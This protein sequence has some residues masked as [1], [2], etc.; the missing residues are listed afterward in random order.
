MIKASIVDSPFSSGLPPGPTVYTKVKYDIS[1]LSAS[2]APELK[3]T[4]NIVSS[5]KSQPQIA[6]DTPIISA[7]TDSLRQIRH[8]CRSSLSFL[9]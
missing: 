2:T 6:K 7:P 4:T 9:G 5:I 3:K 8:G 1:G